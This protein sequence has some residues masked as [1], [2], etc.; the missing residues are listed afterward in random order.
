MAQASNLPSLEFSDIQAVALRYMSES[1]FSLVERA[2]QV[3]LKAHAKQYRQSG[4]PYIQHPLHVCLTLARINLDPAT[5][6]AAFLHDVVEDTAS[7]LPQIRRLFGWRIANLVDGVTKLD[8]IEIQKGFFAFVWQ[9][10]HQQL[11]RQEQRLES[12]RKM[13]LATSKDIRVILIKLADRLHNMETLSGMES[14]DRQRD[15]AQETLEIYAPIAYRLGIGQ[16]KGRLEDLAFASLYPKEYQLL[17]T[18]IKRET[19]DRERQIEK[20]RRIIMKVLAQ[21]SLQ[22]EIHTRIKH[23]YSLYR[24]LNRYDNDLSKIY[25]LVACRIIVNSV[26]DCYRVMGLIHQRWKPVDGR[27]KDYIASPK[28]NGYQSL[29]TTVKAVEDRPIEIQIRTKAM[30]RQAEYGIAAHWRYS[31]QK[32]TLN[33]LRRA[34]SMARKGELSW[35]N[36]LARWQRAVKSYKDLDQIMKID[37]F[38][39]RIF[40]YTPKGEVIDLPIGST[41]IDFAYAIHSEVGHHLAGA[42]VNGK[43]ARLQD[44]LQSGDTVELI[45][46]KKAEPKPDWL[47]ETKTSHAKTHIRRALRRRDLIQQF[48]MNNN[49]NNK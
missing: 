2:Y 24:K 10:Q 35:V 25:D 42:K 38:G 29:H 4:E 36:E 19:S 23:L 47:K 33:Y 40:A 15:I 7:S 43:M 48:R 30:H 13:L 45:I 11:S 5:L 14:G 46:Q 8:K 41:S 9:N 34:V 44:E 49:Q 28:P 39:D 6:A 17:V 1:D 32:G 21:A 16:I 26:E 27:V 12:L 3:A 31:E 20:A 22:A 18:R 37:F